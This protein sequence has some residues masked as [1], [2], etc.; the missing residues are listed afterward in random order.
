ME[1]AQRSMDQAK[2]DAATRARE[3][4]ID[5]FWKRAL[6]FGGFLT[7]AFAGL[8]TARS[9]NPNLAV[10]VAAFGSVC[11]WTWTLANRGSKFWYESWEGKLQD[12][13]AAITGPLFGQIV[14]PRDKGWLAARRYS[15]SRLAIGLS[16]FALI[17]WACI[18]SNEV[19]GLWCQSFPEQIGRI[20]VTVFA[21]GSVAYAIVLEAMCRVSTQAKPQN[22]S[23]K[24][25]A[26]QSQDSTKQ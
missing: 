7:I 2:Y 21:I 19:I 6:F 17:V 4:E 20:A 25:E 5:L 13:E 26:S 18:L 3:F 11:A 10:M 24:A 23:D 16:D 12:A 14:L 1:Q 22:R 15:V 8:V 9:S